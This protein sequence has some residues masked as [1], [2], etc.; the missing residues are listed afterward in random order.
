[1]EKM[2]A[3][4]LILS[5]VITW[6]IGLL[7]PL[8]I[9]YVFLKRPIAKWPAIGTC[10]LFWV[11]NIIIFTFM[12]SQSKTHFALTLIAF[13]SYWLLRRGD[14]VKKEEGKAIAQEEK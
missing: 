9:R 3:A 6:S 11:L 7:P 4:T 13:V 1:M 8:L 2:D 12:G 10:A 5:F 14:E